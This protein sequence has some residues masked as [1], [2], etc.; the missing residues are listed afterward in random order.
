MTKKKQ[1][2]CEVGLVNTWCQNTCVSVAPLRSLTT[3]P[4]HFFCVVSLLSLFSE[5]LGWNPDPGYTSPHR[6]IPTP[7]QEED[8]PVALL[9]AGFPHYNFNNIFTTPVRCAPLPALW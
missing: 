8:Q 6:W 5:K 3:L 4:S 7:D 9:N 2:D 1:R